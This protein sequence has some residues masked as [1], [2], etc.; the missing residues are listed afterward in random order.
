MV[1]DDGKAE[2]LMPF[3]LLLEKKNEGPCTKHDFLL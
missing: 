2:E 3:A 1:S